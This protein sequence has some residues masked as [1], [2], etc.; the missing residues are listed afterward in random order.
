[1]VGWA[2]GVSRET[3]DCAAMK[4]A[5][6][7]FT[8]LELMTALTVLAVLVAIATPS[9]RQF[10]AN[11][12]T[13]ATANS[14][15]NALA[16]ARSEALR[17]AMPVAICGSNNGVACTGSPDWSG[18]WLVFTDNSGT[19]GALDATDIPIQY[20][21]A[22]SGGATVNMVAANADK[23]VRFNARGMNAQTTTDTFT[24]SVPGCTGNNISQIVVTVSG[25]PQLTKLACP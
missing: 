3:G 17:R 19:A 2:R 20:W 5:Q 8:L 11:S 23:Y 9:F 18:G 13:A 14:V 16:V 25:S 24:I 1:L 15:A 21:P 7:G 12:R 4:T 22:P 10:S 6:H